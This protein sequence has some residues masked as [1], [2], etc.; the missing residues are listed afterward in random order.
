MTED[1][2][3]ATRLRWAARTP[4]DV[5]SDFVDVGDFPSLSLR[6]SPR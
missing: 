2:V 4:I 3:L 5:P 6:A 1:P